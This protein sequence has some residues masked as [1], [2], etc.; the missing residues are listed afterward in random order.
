MTWNNHNP[1]PYCDSSDA[2]NYNTET[3]AGKCW[4]CEAVYPKDKG[5]REGSEE[6]Y[7]IKRSN[8]IMSFVPKVEGEEVFED[9]RGIRAETYQFYNATTVLDGQGNAVKHIYRYPSGGQKIRMLQ[10][11]DFYA[12]NLKTDEFFGQNL[13][14]SG[15]GKTITICEGEL[16]AMSAYQMMNNPKFPTPF[17]SLP[18]AN[19]S[20]KLWEKTREYLSGFEKII[21]STDNDD[22]GNAIAAKIAKIFPNKVYRVIHDKYKDAN[23]FLEAGAVKEYQSAWWNAKKYVP[24]NVMNTSQQFLSMYNNAEE[25][26]YVPTGIP[27]FDELA[28]GLMQGHFTVFKAQ[29]GIGKTEFMRYLQYRILS[30]YPDIS[31]AI[32]HLEETK[33]RSLLGLCSYHLQDNLTRKDIIEEKEADELVQQAIVELTEHERLFQFY[34]NDEDDPLTLLDQIRYLSQACGCRYIMFEPIQDVAASKAGDES[35]EAFLADM[36]IRLT[37]LAAELNVGIITIAH[38]N[39][40]GAVKYCKMIEQRASVVV[41]LQRDKMAED[42]TDRN[43]TRLFITKNRPTGATGFAGEMLFNSDTFTLGNKWTI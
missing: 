29:T 15:V 5:Y 2:F 9:Y 17:V 13:W 8:N 7:P 14:N 21:L 12:Q 42:P 41:E 40:D 20:R 11:K 19:P 34:L 6:K 10:Q 22:A 30:Q 35:K 1:C 28:M 33:L 36:A 32:W 4:S 37:K 18:S 3:G 26:I 27:D 16:D 39:D 43:T 23:E 24:E 25:H 38:T 31:L